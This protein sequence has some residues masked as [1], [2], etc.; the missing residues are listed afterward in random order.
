MKQLLCLVRLCAISPLLPT[1]EFPSSI[2][3]QSSLP[4][5]SRVQLLHRTRLLQLITG[6]VFFF[7]LYSLFL[8]HTHTFALYPQFSLFLQ[9]FLRLNFLSLCLFIFVFQNFPL[10]MLISS[11]F[12]PKM[13]ELPITQLIFMFFFIKKKSSFDFMLG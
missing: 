7:F 13:L 4:S 1:T 10:L 8:H 11:D 3:L 6:E 5:T 12:T 9:K 2:F